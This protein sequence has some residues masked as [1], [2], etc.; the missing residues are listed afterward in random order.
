MEINRKGFTLV[1]LVVGIIVLGIVVAGVI[2]ILGSMEVKSV[3]PLFQVK[4]DLLAHRIYNQIRQRDFDENSD[5]SGGEC[6]C[7]ENISHYGVSVCNLKDCTVAS[8]FGPDGDEKINLKQEFFNDVDDFDTGSLCSTATLSG[9]CLSKN[10]NCKPSD[11]KCLNSINAILTNVC[12][13]SDNDCLIPAKFFVDS[14]HNISCIT[15]SSDIACSSYD[16]YFVNIH[17]SYRDLSGV[18]VKNIKIV[19]VSP[20]YDSFDYQFIR[21]NY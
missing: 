6:R 3:E 5:H 19:V 20:R 9:I 4:A 11:A 12:G 17:V 7:G 2:P 16:G 10:N 1:E 21:G 15:E 18:S 13:S 8:D 14:T